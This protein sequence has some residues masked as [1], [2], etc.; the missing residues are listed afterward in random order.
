M[1]LCTQAEAN[2]HILRLY[3]IRRRSPKAFTSIDLLP[4]S[5]RDNDSFEGEIN[6]AAFSPD[7]IYLAL[8][9]IDNQTHLYDRRM[10]GRQCSEP[11]FKYHHFGESKTASKH[12]LYGVVQAQWVQSSWTTRTCLVT[13]GE[14]GEHPIRSSELGFLKPDLIGCVRMWDPSVSA[15]D[16]ENGKVLAEV[17]SD[18]SQFSIGDPFVGEYRLVV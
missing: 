17:H 2:H 12:E 1:G 14:D 18:I 16:V 9:R 10:L 7:Q 6:V 5:P 3:D 11:L 8:A 15:H 4:F 13:G